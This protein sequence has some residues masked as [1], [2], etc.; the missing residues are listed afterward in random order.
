[1]GMF[2]YNQ[3]PLLNS[4]TISA[5]ICNSYEGQIGAAGI[6]LAQA[7]ATNEQ[8]LMASIYGF[9]KARGLPNYAIPRLVRIT[10]Q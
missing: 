4:I 10:Q 6:S 3:K 9:L 1:M 2:S 5:N 7:G 8:E